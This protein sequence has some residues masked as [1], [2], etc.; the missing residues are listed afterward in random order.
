M[1]HLTNLGFLLFRE[2]STLVIIGIESERFFFE[3]FGVIINFVEGRSDTKDILDPEKPGWF[4]CKI[5]LKSLNSQKLRQKFIL[6][7]PFRRESY[8]HIEDII[9]ITRNIKVS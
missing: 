9:I 5:W 6:N 1:K 7:E 8:S 3:V 2:M 4:F